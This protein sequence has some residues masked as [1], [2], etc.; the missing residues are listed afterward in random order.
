MKVIETFKVR[1][2][3]IVVT[4]PACGGLGVI[5]LGPH[6]KTIYIPPVTNGG[7]GGTNW[8]Q[9]KQNLPKYL[10]QKV[11]GLDQLFS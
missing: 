2:W 4:E 9:T 8:E 1:S 7:I 10:F 11:K 3:E 6:G 5:L